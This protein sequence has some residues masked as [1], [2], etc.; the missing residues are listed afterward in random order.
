MADREIGG[1]DVGDGRDGVFE[2]DSGPR[3]DLA[4]GLERGEVKVDFGHAGVAEHAVDLDA[5]DSAF[6]LD[7]L[8]ER[9]GRYPVG[10]EPSVFDSLL[11]VGHEEGGRVFDD[12]GSLQGRNRGGG[13]FREGGEGLGDGAGT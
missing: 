4:F 10:V 9:G 12:G 13:D 7:L 8:L 2:R 11:D 3:E 6:A 1:G 5:D